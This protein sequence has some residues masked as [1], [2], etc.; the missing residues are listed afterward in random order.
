MNTQF[1]R[2]YQEFDFDEVRKHLL[3]MGDL[4]GDCAS[5]RALGI[6]AYQARSCP[7]CGTEFKYLTSRR[8]ESHP[9]ERFQ[10]VRR[11]KEKRPD[12]PFLDYTDFQKTL[13]QLQARN[14]FG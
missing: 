10:L 7:E 9:G 13:G 5:C 3:I 4:S 12:L 6:D 2:I 14:F 11:M 1:L 8:L